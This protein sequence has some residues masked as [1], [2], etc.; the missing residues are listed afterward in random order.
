M[1]DFGLACVSSGP[2]FRVKQASGTIGYAC[3]YY[4]QRGVVTEASE[5]YSFGTVL[6]ELL[7][8]A[9]AACSGASG[10]ILYLVSHLRGDMTRLCQMIDKRADWPSSVT[11]AL[12]AFALKCV[13]LDETLR[14][15]FVAV[16]RFLRNLLIPPIS[17]DSISKTQVL[18]CPFVLRVEL[19][20]VPGNFFSL[21]P[22]G[23]VFGRKMIEGLGLSD[24]LR[25]TIS[26]EH[27]RMRIIEGGRTIKIQHIGINPVIISSP[28]GEPAFIN[29]GESANV[30][31]GGTISFFSGIALPILPFLILRLENP[32]P[33]CECSREVKQANSENKNESDEI[34]DK[35]LPPEESIEESENL[36]LNN[37]SGSK[38]LKKINESF[39]GILEVVAVRGKA[40]SG[41]RFA[42]RDSFIFG[43]SETVSKL[44]GSEGALVPE[45]F[46]HLE[47]SSQKAVAKALAED[48]LTVACFR[49]GDDEFHTNLVKQGQTVQLEHEDFIRVG[50]VMV[51]RF[52]Y[53][54]NP[55]KT[56]SSDSETR[57]GESVEPVNL[58]LPDD[59]LPDD[60]L[61]PVT[62]RSLRPAPALTPPI[63]SKQI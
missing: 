6:L 48:G 58:C 59:M 56:M 41:P 52:L 50:E 45:Q 22:S 29:K 54:E 23:L 3:P 42:I 2:S 35:Q 5:V 25:S 46:M 10:E 9:P 13:S 47:F 55:H 37:L 11:Q 57:S 16:V 17:D 38:N 44:L 31:V 39:S 4:I 32:E 51:L 63:L 33:V 34:Y 40:V 18:V 53:Q 7:C 19:P 60:R 43:A 20:D 27:L 36:A 28:E 49:G 26:R 12:G 24:S 61:S 62:A 21:S 8:N 14:P 1:A 30:A 15:N